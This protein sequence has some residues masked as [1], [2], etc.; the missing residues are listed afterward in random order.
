MANLLNA[1]RLGPA[2]GGQQFHQL[3]LRAGAGS[4]VPQPNLGYSDTGLGQDAAHPWTVIV[5]HLLFP[6]LRAV[7]RRNSTPSV[8]LQYFC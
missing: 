8:H 2:D 3:A 6:D 7:P 5:A 1:E 4:V